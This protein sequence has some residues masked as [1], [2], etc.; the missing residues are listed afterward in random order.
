M[1][2]TVTKN[3]VSINT[4]YILNDKEYNV[5][6]CY[7]TFSDEYTD[8]LVKKAIFVQGTSTIEMSIINNQCQIPAE[9]LNNGQFELRV[10]A[11]EVD[12]EELLLRYSPSYTTAYVR[13][14]SYIENAESPEVITPTQFE[15]YMQA[16]NDGL[17]EVANVDI[18][19]EQLDNGMSV[20]ITNRYGENKT[21]YA[22]DGEK[23]E[24]GATGATG[25]G[26]ASITKTSTSGLTDTYT[27]TFTNGN[28]TIFTV[29]NGKGIVSVEKT[30]TN[31]LA[32]TYT[33]TYNDNT[34]SSFV[35]MN[36]KGIA[37]IELTS[38]SDLVDTYTITY[39]DN[40]TTTYN[41][42]NGNGIL[43]IEKT[44]TVDNVD[45][46]TIYYT[47]GT[48]S[49]FTVTNS[50]VTDQ[51]FETLET[52]VNK[53]KT[54]SLLLP[55]VTGEGSSIELNDT[56][57]GVTIDITPEGNTEQITY[58]GKN[59]LGLII[60]R[61]DT[62][63]GVTITITPDGYVKLH[64]T[65]N[66]NINKS[67]NW[68]I[69]GSTYSSKEYTYSST[70][71]SGTVSN[72]FAVNIRSGS[73][74]TSTSNQFN[75]N[76]LYVNNSLRKETFT[77]SGSGY[78]TGIQF[79]INNG[80]SFNNFI[81]KLQV[82]QGSTVTDYEPYV[83]GTPSP[84]PDYPQDIRVVKGDNTIKINSKNLF[85]KDNANILNASINS[86]GVLSSNSNCKTIYIPIK[87]NT[88][89]TIQKIISTQFRAS[90]YDDIPQ[91]NSTGT[92]TISNFIGTSITITSTNNSKYLAVFCYINTDTLTEQEIL[93]SI[94]IEQGS[95]ATDYEPYQN[96]TYPIYLGDLELCKIGDY[97]DYIYKENN[98]WYIHKDIGKVVLD[99]SENWERSSS[100]SNASFTN[101]SGAKYI[102]DSGD[103]NIYVYCDYYD[104]TYKTNL[105]NLSYCCALSSNSNLLIRNV[106]FTTNNNFK[107]WLSTHNTTVYYVLETPTTTEIT[108]T[109]LINQLNNLYSAVA[110]QDKTFI[111][112]TST[113]LNNVPL[114]V[115]AITYKDISSILNPVMEREE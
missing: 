77:A 59:L 44:G 79:I 29:S 93:D 54:L 52:E 76:S 113:D 97:Q 71:S 104:R 82:E 35:I 10:Y 89:Y 86:S 68:A 58:T 19:A 63:N 45:T 87:S 115:K 75:P 83:G 112:C 33:I 40:T 42:T 92:N 12:G 30:G 107:N 20:T 47:N 5:N 38:T 14:G 8:D 51:E 81:I 66:D 41:V 27:I 50:T 57:E 43:S 60:G 84:N 39:N 95:T 69:A 72:N 3:Q 6:K 96:Q 70:Y 67:Y 90:V 74:Q 1:N 114:I 46:Y 55:K 28:T 78:I 2:I 56:V 22:Y 105:N 110:N 36:G 61:T 25:N 26:I 32:D 100:Y 106:D 18:D 15:Q 49:T 103:N 65:A 4:D 64:G 91:I 21:V 13:T 101:I 111:E 85:D 24:T 34:T 53:Y 23:G 99:G 37:S 7:F 98:K 16:M 62:V 108:D 48:T 11:Y 88:T 9:V 80:V 31:L 109:T 73:T 102:P 17:N 94:Q